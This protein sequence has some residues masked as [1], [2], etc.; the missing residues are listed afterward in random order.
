[1]IARLAIFLLVLAATAMAQTDAPKWI[2]RLKSA[3]LSSIETGMPET[4]F[5][6][7]FAGVVHPAAAKYEMRECEDPGGASSAEKPLC[8]QASADVANG[9]TVELTMK[10][11]SYTGEGSG[12][13]EKP[14]KIELLMGQ[15]RP[16]N[17]MSK[18]PSRVVR[19][20]SDLEAL[21]R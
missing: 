20:L 3:P 7:W 19:K 2:D 10:V 15:L 1:M 16:T 13:T 18:Q 6:A 11:G 9:R 17:P 5:D 4:R 12:R 21:V 14:A 8:V